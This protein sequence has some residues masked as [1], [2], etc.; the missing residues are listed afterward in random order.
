MIAGLE[1]CEQGRIELDGKLVQSP[2]AERGLVFQEYAL[3][4]WRTVRE[5]VG[6]GLELRGVPKPELDSTVS[7][8][9]NMIGLSKFENSLPGELS[10]GMRQRVAIA[11][12]LWLY[13]HPCGTERCVLPCQR[14]AQPGN[15]TQTGRSRYLRVEPGRPRQG[16]C[17]ECQRPGSTASADRGQSHP[18]AIWL[19]RAA[20]LYRGRC[21]G[22][23]AIRH[24]LEHIDHEHAR[25]AGL[26]LRQAISHP[27]CAAHSRTIAAPAGIGGR[28]AR[29]T[30]CP[31]AVSP[32]ESQGQLSGNVLVHCRT[33]YHCRCRM[34]GTFR[35]IAMI[36]A[37]SRKRL[38]NDRRI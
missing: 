4:P 32:Q 9:V 21:P 10:G 13:R 20:R 1:P 27:E 8:F 30:D 2:G 11:T 33:A 35:W 29:G 3:F 22:C 31:A 15:L 28:M 19:R 36:G 23:L 7:R 34:G 14:P 5:N 38:T 16:M 18:L 37:A 17:R 6:F 25:R 12:V 26:L 24:R